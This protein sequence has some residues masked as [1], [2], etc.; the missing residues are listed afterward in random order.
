MIRAAITALLSAIA[1]GMLLVQAMDVHVYLCAS[2]HRT[3]TASWSEVCSCGS[4]YVRRVTPQPIV[5]KA[6]LL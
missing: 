3:W 4:R 1:V 6:G 5:N 2:C